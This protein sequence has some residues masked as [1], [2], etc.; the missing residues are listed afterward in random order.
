MNRPTILIADRH[1]HALATVVARMRAVGIS[2]A[3]AR[4]GVEA[5]A[6]ARAVR[7]DLAVL[8]CRLPGLSGPE[9]CVQL[10]HDPLTAHIP[11]ILTLDLDLDAQAIPTGN[12]ARVLGKPFSPGEL[13]DAVLDVLGGNGTR[14]IAFTSAA[15]CASAV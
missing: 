10:V 9:L 15:E 14:S 2:V 6:L 1:T 5:Y 8:D 3:A 4:D 12:I 13:V 11:V 7:P